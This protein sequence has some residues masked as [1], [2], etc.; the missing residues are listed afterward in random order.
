MDA[1]PKGT[2]SATTETPLDTTIS[3]DSLESEPSLQGYKDHF[4]ALDSQ[5]L[6]ILSLSEHDRILS[7]SRH[8]EIADAMEQVLAQPSARK[9]KSRARRLSKLGRI[10][11]GRRI[12][13]V[14][15][16]SS[17]LLPS[18]VEDDMEWDEGEAEDDLAPLPRESVGVVDSD[19]LGRSS[20]G[21]ASSLGR[22]SAG[23]LSFGRRASSL[24]RT[25][26]TR[27][28]LPGTTSVPRAS[29]SRSSMTRALSG[30]RSSIEQ[31][32]HLLHKKK[33]QTDNVLRL[34]IH[35]KLVPVAALRNVLRNVSASWRSIAN[36]CAP[37]MSSSFPHDLDVLAVSPG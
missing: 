10:A 26:M 31:S 29:M 17:T 4:S 16:A 7:S 15:I 19:S 18:L 5:K 22:A 23:K 14:P 33:L 28:S 37:S 36:M 24:T 13:L 12:S 11:A 30:R 27:S 20:V 6:E 9:E 21:R 35:S 3:M 32:H 8:M 25:T 34:V 1:K 2:T